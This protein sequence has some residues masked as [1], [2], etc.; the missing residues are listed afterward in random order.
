ML[1]ITSKGVLLDSIKLNFDSDDDEDDDKTTVIYT[2]KP[3]F[4]HAPELQFLAYYISKFGDFV[5][6]QTR[7][8]LQ[9]DLPNYVRTF[10]FLNQ[11]T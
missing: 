4:K 5:I 8:M 11:R 3:S 7:I 6:G 9:N 1:H 10:W 2:M